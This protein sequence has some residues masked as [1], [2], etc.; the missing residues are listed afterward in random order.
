MTLKCKVCSGTADMFGY[1]DAQRTCN[2]AFTPGGPAIPY[3]QC[4]DCGFLFT[5]TFDGGT[6]DEWRHRIY[7]SDYYKVDPDIITGDRV[8][9]LAVFL[10]RLINKYNLILDYGSWDGAL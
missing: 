8:R 7:N 5:V 10:R 4:R 3:H 9:N 1:A 2:N 6:P